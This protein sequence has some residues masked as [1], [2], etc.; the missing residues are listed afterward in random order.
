MTNYFYGMS[1]RYTLD[2]SEPGISSY[3]YIQP[4]KVDGDI[5]TK[6]FNKINGPSCK[7]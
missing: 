6:A 4:V 7:Y 5:L 3:L 2:G 1:L